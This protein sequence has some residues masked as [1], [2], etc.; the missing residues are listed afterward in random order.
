MARCLQKCCATPLCN[1]AVYDEV[2]SGSC[3]LFDCGSTED[4]KCQFTAN[5]Q[6]VSAV[7]DINRHQF[8][9]VAADRAQDHTDQLE[10]LR[11]REPWAGRRQQQVEE[12]EQQEGQGCGRWQFQCHS[13]ECIA[14]Y[15][16]CNGIPQCEDGS[17]EDSTCPSTTTTL[18]PTTQ[19]QATTKHVHIRPDMDPL[20]DTGAFKHKVL[21][22]RSQ[23]CECK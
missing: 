3:Y 17:D 16:V 15:D 6:F 8:D 2:D 23:N 20:P 14:I 18:P 10:M 11:D 22:P 19:T 13:G 5:D 12:E 7:L 4:F 1:V 21:G 9:R